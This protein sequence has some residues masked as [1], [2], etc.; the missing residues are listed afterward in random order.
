MNWASFIHA[1]TNPGKLEVTLMIIGET[2]N[3]S[4]AFK[5]VH[6]LLGHGTVKSALSQEFIDKLNWF[7]VCWYIF[8]KATVTQ[9]VNG[10]VWSNIG[11]AF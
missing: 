4:M 11:V 6:G 10:W 3:V 2:S 5:Y 8:R 1:D 9:I 7:F